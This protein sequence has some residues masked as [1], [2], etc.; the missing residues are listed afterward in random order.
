MVTGS[1][2]LAAGVCL[3]SLLLTIGCA[4]VTQGSVQTIKLETLTSAGE[5]VD[6]ADCRLSNEK[7]NFVTPSGASA[8]VG[9]A[10]GDLSVRCTLPGRS[11]ALGTAVSRGNAGLAGNILFGGVIG[12]A[13]DASTGAAYSYP[14][15]IQLVFGEE[16]LFDRSG[17]RHDGPVAGQLV[18]SL[19]PSS[20]LNV[21][22]NAR[23]APV[24]TPRLETQAEAPPP[25]ASAGAREPKTGVYAPLQ[26]GDTLEYTL[27]DDLTGNRSTVQYTLDRVSGEEMS[28]NAGSR[29]ERR[30]GTVVAVRP[31]IG[32]LHDSAMPSGGWTRANVQVGQ[33]WSTDSNGYSLTGRAASESAF[34]IDG[35]S[36]RVI[37]IRYTGWQTN[38]AP[39]N[40][41]TQRNTPV[42]FAVLYSPEL[43]RVVRLKSETRT[44]GSPAKETFALM[45]ILRN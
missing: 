40:G 34:T 37:D 1:R 39:G 25:Q 20:S 35:E 44:F 7:G 3:G 23:S 11:P 14:S 31:P 29:I 18:R 8:I 26:R 43:K 30:D 19:A 13:V 12:A 24:S 21:G 45:R 22:G 32:G 15:W 36:L 2:I 9:R 41:A 38:S 42:E 5:T 28:F 10:P 6:G 4:S 33:S 27:T 17:N 16:R